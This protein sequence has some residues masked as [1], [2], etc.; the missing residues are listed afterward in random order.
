MLKEMGLMIEA[1]RVTIMRE[2]NRVIIRIR[3]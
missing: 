1:N 3:E 2:L